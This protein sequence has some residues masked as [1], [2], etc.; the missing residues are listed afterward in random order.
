MIASV[1][2]QL[3]GDHGSLAQGSRVCRLWWTE[4]HKQLWRRSQLVHLLLVKDIDR[5]RYFAS[6]VE[7][8]TF[9]PDDNA[10]ASTQ[11]ERE[12]LAF[13]R[14]ATIKMW[15]S[16]L[17]D[18]VP[19]NIESL[20]VPSLRTLSI[21][22]HPISWERTSE[23]DDFTFLNALSACLANLTT[24]R[25]EIGNSNVEED[26]LFTLFD[27]LVAVEHLE[28][29]H[30]A[31]SLF[32]IPQPEDFLQ[33]ML[34]KPNLVSLG[35]PHGCE[36][37]AQS[38]LIFLNNMGPRWFLPTLRSL[39]RPVFFC[40]Q[41][42]ASLL[43]RLPNL[44]Y[45]EIELDGSGWG[46]NLKYTFTAISKLQHLK[47]IEI[48]LNVDDYDMDGSWLVQLAEVKTLGNIWI[49]F[50]H[51]ARTTLIGAQF[52]AF[53]TGLT[54][55]KHLRLWICSVEV[56]CSPED[57]ITIDTAIEKI[58]KCELG[59]LTLTTQGVL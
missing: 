24:L 4:G 39:S 37:T 15:Q 38:V 22:P 52:A 35:F 11:M 42:A 28:I 40:S 54:K 6:L 16:N 21:Q 43:D 56:I 26:Q 10:L 5:R 59:E 32:S 58:D 25:F 45:L 41:A 36:F 13:S 8:L 33:R 34:S 47:S 29:G 18:V 23:Q 1:F 48:Q 53:L 44:D 20:I 49:L 17:A 7:K 3:A 55:L 14:L 2:A 9:S 57:K 50:S 46:D 30:I 27:G 31:E 51:P 12:P 19:L